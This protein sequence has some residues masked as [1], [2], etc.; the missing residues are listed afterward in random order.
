MVWRHSAL[1]RRAATRHA[2]RAR[3]APA[4]CEVR[5]ARK[6]R[7]SRNTSGRLTT[8]SSPLSRL[9]RL[10]ADLARQVLGARLL[11]AADGSTDGRLAGSPAKLWH[12]A[13]MAK[14]GKHVSET[15][16][17]A[18]LRVHG[19]EFTKHLYTYVDRGGTEESSRQL[20]VPHHQVIKTLVMQDE[21][22]QPL[23]VLM[24]GDWQVSTKSLARVIGAKS[25]EPCKP[26]VAQR[27]SGYMVGG[28]SPFGLRKVMPTYV[29]QTI[30]DQ[31]RIFINGGRRGFLVGVEPKIL[32]APLGAQPVQ[33]AIELT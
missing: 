16:A 18:W 21:R 1:A 31:Q 12:H 14:E 24:H 10:G 25:I 7:K 19:I 6:A 27:H 20:G 28:T 9:D 2:R 22:A 15:P 4:R 23:I 5:I 17:T 11:V 32:V 33:C 13:L 26:D 8:R 29:E 30:L 3:N